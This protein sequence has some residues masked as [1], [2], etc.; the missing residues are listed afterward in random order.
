MNILITGGFG[1]I[2]S[3]LSKKLSKLGHKITIWDIVDDI[4]DTQFNDFQI[5]DLSSTI[6]LRKSY[7]L[8]YH[9]AS[10]IG[11][12]NIIE[13]SNE[14]LIKSL[15][16]NMNI[17]TLC[18]RYNIPIIYASSS[19]VF[20][21]ATIN[22][23]SDYS[24]KKITDSPRWSYAA[25]KVTGECLFHTANYPSS[26]IRFFNVVGPGQIT[27]GMVIPTFI[28]ACKKNE[29]MYLIENG[30]RNY[31]DIRDAINQIIHIGLDLAIYENNSKM[32][33]QDFNISS[34][35][36]DNTIDVFKLSEIIADVYNS[37][38]TLM[39]KHDYNTNTLKLK[40][41]I[42][43][44]D[45]DILNSLNIA[46]YGVIEI[47]ENIRDLESYDIIHD[48]EEAYNESLDHLLG[49]M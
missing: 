15:K 46:S 2:G 21:S 11:V 34:Q 35:N 8:V 1:F 19:E 20:G 38:S 36:D 42:P 4:N 39:I 26:I 37:K 49:D 16:I 45:N 33:K 31:C 10:P 13:N 24:I 5:I 40:T 32:N 47:I 41:R 7:D 28:E 3:H 17:H 9:L 14:T 18:S 43:E 29:N 12:K 44:F 30:I 25:S 23:D 22:T 48:S 27:D 6:D